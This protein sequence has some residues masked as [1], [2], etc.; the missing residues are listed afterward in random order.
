MAFETIKAE[1][2][3]LLEAID[4][5][6][7]DKHEFYLALREKLNEMRLLGM[8]IPEDLARVESELEAEFLARR[9]K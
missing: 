8:P 6:P 5:R 9:T 3:L 7:E 2:A 4:K 1:I